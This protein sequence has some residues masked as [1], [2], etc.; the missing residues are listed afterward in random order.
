MLDFGDGPE[1]YRF[2]ALN[3]DDGLDVVTPDSPLGQALANAA[4]GQRLTYRTPHGQASVTLV[5]VGGPAA[6]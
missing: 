3:I 2:T 4:P 6:A 5:S 1:T